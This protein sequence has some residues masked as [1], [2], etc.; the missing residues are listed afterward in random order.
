M[1]G[2]FAANAVAANVLETNGLAVLATVTQSDLAA[3]P[4][5]R[6]CLLGSSPYG[7][8]YVRADAHHDVHDVHDV[9][10]QDPYFHLW[11]EGS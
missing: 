6:S 2:P 10:A 3:D 1:Y 7:D 9:H 5:V 4:G 8:S 11:A